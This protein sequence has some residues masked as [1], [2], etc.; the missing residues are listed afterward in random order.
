MAEN[1]YSSAEMMSMQRDAIRRVR[2]MQRRA[3][4]RV[5]HSS[6]QPNS[7]SRMNGGQHQSVS[8]HHTAQMPSHPSGSSGQHNQVLSSSGTSFLEK[9]NLDQEKLILLLLIVLLLNEGA[10]TKLILAL[11]YLLI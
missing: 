3:N 11:C 7:A 10:D 1:R 8:N 9:L 6:G 5:Q 2:E 4:E